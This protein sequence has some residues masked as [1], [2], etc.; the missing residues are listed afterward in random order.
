MCFLN[1]LSVQLDIGS[2]QYIIIDQKILIIINEL[3]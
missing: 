1:L 3:T 2:V